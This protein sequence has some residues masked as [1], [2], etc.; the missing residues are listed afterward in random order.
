MNAMSTFAVSGDIAGRMSHPLTFNLW[1]SVYVVLGIATVGPFAMLG[2]D[3][4]T[5]RAVARGWLERAGVKG[6]SRVGVED[7]KFMASFVVVTGQI[8]R[9]HV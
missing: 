9:A 6:G 2:M 1:L 3:A 8:G 4:L 7:V 5:E